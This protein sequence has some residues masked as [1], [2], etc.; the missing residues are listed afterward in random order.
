M[1]NRDLVHGGKDCGCRGTRMEGFLQPCLLLMLYEKPTHGYELMENMGRLGFWE[2]VPDAGA[3]YRNL[4]RMEEEG[5]VKSNWSTEGSGPARRLYEITRE[6]I[7][8]L[9]D[10]AVAIRRHKAALETFLKRYESL[11]G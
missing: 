10:W 8:L 4:R 1:C 5:L 3:V 6:G 2:G 11:F 7:D 9:H